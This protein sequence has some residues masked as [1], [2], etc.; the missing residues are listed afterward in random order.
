MIYNRHLSSGACV[1]SRYEGDND[2]DTRQM[3]SMVVI[4]NRLIVNFNMQNNN[5][6]P[7]MHKSI[8]TGRNHTYRSRARL[9]GEGLHSTRNVVRD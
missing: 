7:Y 4:K 6:T 1:N 5:A 3:R 9:L 8:F 2:A